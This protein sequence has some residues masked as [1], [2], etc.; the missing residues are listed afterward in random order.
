MWSGIPTYL[1]FFH[2]LLSS[3]QVKGFR[4]VN[5]PDI[6]VFWNSLGF[7]MIE[8]MVVIGNLVSSAFSKSRFF[9]WKSLV[10][11]LFKPSLENFEHYFASM[12]DECTCAVVWM[13]FSIGMKSDLFQSCGHCW[14]FQICWHIECSTFTASSLR[15]WNSSAG[16][17]SPPLT[18]FVV[19][20]LKAHLTSHSRMSGSRGVITPSSLSGSLRSFLYSSSVYSWYLFLISSASVSSVPF[21]YF[22][23]PSLHEMFPWYL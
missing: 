23:V 7:S 4:V 18:L 11:V 12:W 15:I 10:H 17:L 6:D 22:I 14:V 3:T 20:L 5:E 8:W 21:L 2:S 1:K 9:I 13:F 16:I 19:M